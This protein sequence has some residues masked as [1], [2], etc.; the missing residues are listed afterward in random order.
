ML[1]VLVSA[2]FMLPTS[3]QTHDLAD[4]AA[5]RGISRLQNYVYA[6]NEGSYSIEVINSG[7]QPAAAAR[8]EWFFN[9]QRSCI[10]EVVLAAGESVTLWCGFGASVGDV[11]VEVR[12]DAAFSVKES[13]E[14]NNIVSNTFKVLPAGQRPDIAIITTATLPIELHTGDDVKLTA[15]LKN[16]KHGNTDTFTFSWFLNEDEKP[17]CSESISLTGLS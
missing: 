17:V 12:L 6:G 5:P 10:N 15:F 4:L 1:N 11:Q 14:R 2:V 7:T 3:A 13:N 8:V 16:L 9:Q